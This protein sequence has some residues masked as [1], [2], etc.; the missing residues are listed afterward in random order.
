MASRTAAGSINRLR[1]L[2]LFG[3]IWLVAIA[4]GHI[5]KA[6]TQNKTLSFCFNEWPPYAA[7]TNDR[8]EGIS[9]DIV[10]QVMA[11]MDKHAD[12]VELPWKRC[13][14]M[15]SD[16]RIDAVMDAASRDEYLQ[17]PTSVSMYSD[18][19]W[20]HAD[21]DMKTIGDLKGSRVGVISGYKYSDALTGKIKDLDLIVDPAVD[22]PTNIRKLAFKRVDAIVGDT[23]GTLHFARQHSLNIRPIQ[24][25]VSFDRLYASFNREKTDLH[26]EFDRVLQTLVDEGAVDEIYRKYLGTGYSDMV[27]KMP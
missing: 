12:F 22:D 19:F 2:A 17:G 3:S 13:L 4:I 1:F 14:Q 23:V 11:R 26:A 5:A 24:P 8:A 18:T 6:E 21:S 15:V 20:V 16:G 10:R 7:M 27:G 9:V 25:P